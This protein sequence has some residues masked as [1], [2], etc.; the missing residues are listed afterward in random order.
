MKRVYDHGPA[1][2]AV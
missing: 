2:E 1:D